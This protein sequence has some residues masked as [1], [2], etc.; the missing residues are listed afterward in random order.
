MSGVEVSAATSRPPCSA[1]APRPPVRSCP[2]PTLPSSKRLDSGNRF[3]VFGDG[4]WAT[5]KAC[6]TL[7]AWDHV[8]RSIMVYAI[9]LSCMLSRIVCCNLS[10][11]VNSLCTFAIKRRGDGI[12]RVFEMVSPLGSLLRTSESRGLAA[13]KLNSG[14]QAWCLPQEWACPEALV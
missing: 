13:V 10:L 14:L 12:A 11:F 6:I 5:E 2:P 9:H 1:S 4:R 8:L 7:F 3:E